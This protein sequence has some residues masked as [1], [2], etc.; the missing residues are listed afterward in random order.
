MIANTSM[1]SW[2]ILAVLTV[3]S[4]GLVI[5][6]QPIVSKSL[7]QGESSSTGAFYDLHR[8]PPFDFFQTQNHYL[9]FNRILNTGERKLDHV[10][11]ALEKKGRFN[12]YISNKTA[13]YYSYN[14]IVR[15]I[16]MIFAF[17]N[18][19]HLIRF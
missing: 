17:L 4:V 5:I 1:G 14:R 7:H 9:F 16:Y 2:F 19:I 8:P 13:Q 10:L 15:L 6:C 18:L 12:L 3:I 11:M